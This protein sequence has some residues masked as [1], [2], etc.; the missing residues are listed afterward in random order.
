MACRV[1][2]SRAC[3]SSMGKRGL[4]KDLWFPW[5]FSSEPVIF[6][7]GGK[8]WLDVSHVDMRLWWL[9]LN[10]RAELCQCRLSRV[11]GTVRVTP[12]TF[13]QTVGVRL[14]VHP[15]GSTFSV[16]DTQFRSCTGA[17]FQLWWFRSFQRAVRLGDELFFPKL[18]G[19]CSLGL[20]AGHCE[21]GVAAVGMGRGLGW[22]TWC[23]G[24]PATSGESGPLLVPE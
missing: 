1:S 4:L 6:I 20:W 15:R 3:C 19:D 5:S 22:Q 23:S 21:G 9:W 10:N 17:S 7:P 12:S 8:F 2:F 13:P 11:L 14:L 18:G 16:D 24:V